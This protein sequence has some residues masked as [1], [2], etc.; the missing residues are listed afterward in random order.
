MPNGPEGDLPGL[1]VEPESNLR[2]EQVELE[3][4]MQ[5]SYLDYAMNVIVARALPEVRAGLKPVAGPSGLTPV[6][7]AS[8]PPDRHR[9]RLRR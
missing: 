7:G 3:R 8:C 6:R 4:E 1:P 9:P 5:R 2:I